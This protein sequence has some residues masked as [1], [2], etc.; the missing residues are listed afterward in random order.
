MSND[1]LR[2]ISNI[3]LPLSENHTN[4]S[5]SIRE[6][7]RNWDQEELEGDETTQCGLCWHHHIKHCFTIKNSINH[8]AIDDVW[9]SCIKKFIWVVDDIPEDEADSYIAFKVIENVLWQCLLKE[10]PD[11]ADRIIYIKDEKINNNRKIDIWELILVT[12]SIKK[13]AHNF[14]N[15]VPFLKKVFSRKLMKT[16]LKRLGKYHIWQLYSSDKQNLRKILTDVQYDCLS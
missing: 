1:Y 5:Q 13:H 12:R 3:M 15:Y 7:V 11:F 10:W 14:D 2:K 16:L 8:H 6:W 4:I 9:S